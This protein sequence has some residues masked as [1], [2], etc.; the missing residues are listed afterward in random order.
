MVRSDGRCA[1][2]APGLSNQE[3]TSERTPEWAMLL[4]SSSNASA[5]TCPRL[6]RA[7]IPAG[8]ASCAPGH[9]RASRVAENEWVLSEVV[10]IVLVVAYVYPASQPI[11]WSEES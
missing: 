8:L 10:F 4:A 3:R 1:G 5:F 11:G 2:L 7:R 6:F 9:W